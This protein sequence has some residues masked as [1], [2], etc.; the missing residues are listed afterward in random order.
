MHTFQF[1]PKVIHTNSNRNIWKNVLQQVSEKPHTFLKAVN[2][3]YVF[4]LSNKAIVYHFIVTYL[5]LGAALYSVQCPRQTS[6]WGQY[7]TYLAIYLADHFKA[8]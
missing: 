2:K 1:I 4:L 8:R 6:L 5:I 3:Q 7:S